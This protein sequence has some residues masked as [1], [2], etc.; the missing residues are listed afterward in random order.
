MSGWIIGIMVE[1]A[2]SP[3]VRHFFAVAKPDRAQAEWA[4][5]DLAVAEG[6]V[7]PSPVGGVEPVDA[8]GA[9]SAATLKAMGLAAGEIRALGVR[10]PRRWLR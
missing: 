5:V 6:G 10:W 9:L 2:G 4:A 7:S 8:V 3:A 1:P